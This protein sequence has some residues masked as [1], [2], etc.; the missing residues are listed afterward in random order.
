M[1]SDRFT[2]SKTGELVS[3]DTLDGK[4]W[5][6]IPGPLPPKWTFPS[7]LWPLLG[8]AKQQLGTLNGIG[9]ILGN[10]ALLLRPLQ[11]REAVRSSSLEGTY[12]TAVQLL[13][14]QLDPKEP[15]SERD[16]VNESREVANYVR[17]L[18]VGFSRLRKLPLSL[19]VIREMH[20]VLLAGVRGKG[21]TPGR[22]RDCQVHV[23]AGRRYIP[24]PAQYV[25]DCLDVFEKYLHSNNRAYDP[26]VL[27]YLVHYQFE[28][29]HP[30]RDGNGRVGRVLLSLTMY[31]WNNLEMPWLYMSAFFERY[32]DEYINGLF[33]VSTHGNWDR[34]IEFCLQGTVSECKDA[35]R[36]CKKL[37]ALRAK[38]HNEADDL[39]DRMHRIVE[40]MF[41]RPVFR[42]SDIRKWCGGISRPTAQKDVDKLIAAGLVNHLRGDR[43]RIYFVPEVFD[44][45]YSEEES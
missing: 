44:A 39:S 20:E 22:F 32:K 16:E 40:H 26:I 8:E 27:C 38:L 7:R 23:G 24:P 37:Y 21:R 25:G 28:A 3:I 11:H 17:A 2:Q 45:A 9:Q 6:F 18:R 14:Y 31:L 10:P 29:I 41:R 33:G 12:T 43:P 36:R 34:W 35:I 13:L 15:K 5:A 1:D 4:D 42:V 30:F 19:R